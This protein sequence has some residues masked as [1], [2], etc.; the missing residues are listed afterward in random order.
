MPTQQI[1]LGLA[2]N[3]TEITINGIS[4]PN[5]TPGVPGGTI[6]VPE[7]DANNLLDQT[8]PS[9]HAAGVWLVSSSST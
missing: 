2:P 7:T 1:T 6:V 5:P 4:Y 9:L 8:P 3:V